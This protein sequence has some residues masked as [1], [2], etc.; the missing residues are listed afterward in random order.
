LARDESGAGM[1]PA[2]GQV[3][4]EKGSNL[5][6]VVHLG[7]AVSCGLGL[8]GTGIADAGMLLQPGQVGI[9]S[10]VSVRRIPVVTPE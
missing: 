5:D 2:L 7:Q 10:P 9:Y 8:R 3:L 6:V 1:L 4:G